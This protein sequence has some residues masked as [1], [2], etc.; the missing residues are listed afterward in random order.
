MLRDKYTEF[1]GFLWSVKWY[2]CKSGIAIFVL[3]DHLKS[4][5]YTEIIVGGGE[6]CAKRTFF[7]PP[8]PPSSSW[9]GGQNLNCKLKTFG[10]LD[11]LKVHIQFNYLASI[12]SLLQTKLAKKKQQTNFFYALHSSVSDLRSV[13]ALSS[14]GRYA[15]PPPSPLCIRPCY[16]PFPG[17]RGCFM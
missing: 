4:R 2:R 12:V 8:S 7:L 11:T 14:R 9:G 10:F 16:A 13:I 5:A 17:P 3:K 1:S 15:W 6:I